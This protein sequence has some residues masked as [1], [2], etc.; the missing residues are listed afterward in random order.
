ML[1]SYVLLDLETTGATPLKDVAL[2]CRVGKAH[3]LRINLNAVKVFACKRN[4]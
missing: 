1:P 2:K 4:Q 3:A